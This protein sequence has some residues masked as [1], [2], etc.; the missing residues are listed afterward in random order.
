MPRGDRTGPYG[1]GPMTGRGAGY[2]AGYG[3]PG[4]ANPAGRFGASGIGRG[5]GGRGRGFSHWFY[6]TGLPGWM[7]FG[8]NLP[9]AYQYSKDDEK[10]FLKEQVD[11][12]S[13]TIENL[14]K[15]LAELEKE[16]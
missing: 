10:S 9:A 12:L 8:Y 16:S 3:V 2:C 13:K 5:F 11:F 15:R 4:Y 14:N 1:A 7:R 6:A